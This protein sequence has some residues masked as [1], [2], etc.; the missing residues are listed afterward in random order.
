MK[1]RE[2][3]QEE[4]PRERL[5]KYGANNLSNEDLIAILLRCGT[6]N[7]NVKELSNQ[8]LMKIKTIDDLNTLGFNE[9]KDIKGMGNV[10]IIT[11][12]AA[13]E[14]GKRVSNKTIKENITLN[15]TNKVNTYFSHLINDYQ[16]HLLVILLD[17]KRRLIS[18]KI[19]YTGTDDETLASPKEIFNYAIKERA[20]AIIIMHNHPSGIVTPSDNDKY[21]TNSL[22]TT[23]KIVG[24]PLLDHIITS[25]S[26]YFSFFDSMVKNEN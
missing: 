26:N 6:K 21:L 9:L 19:M 12:L 7:I 20:S 18:Y 16:E 22:I 4:K 11:L 24:I 3:P 15:N 25:G 2:L 8:I 23:G 5:L 13:I 10:K 17:N 14:L 1:L